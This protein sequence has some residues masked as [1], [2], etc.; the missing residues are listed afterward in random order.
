MTDY[1]LIQGDCLVEMQKLANDNVKTDMVLTDPPYGTTA[2]K[3][4]SIITI[5]QMWE[6]LDDITNLNTPILIFSNDLFGVKLKYSNLKNYKYQWV[7]NK[8]F[9]SN[10]MQVHKRP[11]IP[12]EYINVFYRKQPTYHPQK[13]PKTI[14]YDGS[15]VSEADKKKKINTDDIYGNCYHQRYYVDDGLRYPINFITVN[16]QKN[17]CNNSNRLHPSQKPVELLEYFI[18]TYTDENDTVL[19]FTMGSGSTGVACMNTNRNFI[20]IELEPEYYEIAEQRIQEAKTQR[21]LI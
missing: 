15:R 12:L 5:D 16:S 21:R 10:F 8:E 18:R 7:W 17:E 6:C 4:D 11:L 19:D 1:E 14:D 3:W 13:R 20:G 9:S 2:C